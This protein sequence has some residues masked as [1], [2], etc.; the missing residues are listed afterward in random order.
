MAGCFVPQAMYSLSRG[1]AGVCQVSLKPTD[2]L[3]RLDMFMPL[4]GTGS[5]GSAAFL[6]YVDIS[7][8]SLLFSHT[9]ETAADNSCN[10]D[11][12]HLSFEMSAMG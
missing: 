5:E 12:F 10:E 3:G 1:S 6:L 8:Y 9:L 7:S 11:F 4:V 2:R